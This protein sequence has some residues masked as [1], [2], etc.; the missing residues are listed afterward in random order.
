MVGNTTDDPDG[1]QSIYD[2]E[3]KQVKVLDDQDETSVNIGTTE[4]ASV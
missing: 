3:N 1:R 4:T 2:A